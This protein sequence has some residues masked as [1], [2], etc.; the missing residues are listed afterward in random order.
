MARSPKF[1]LPV[2]FITLLGGAMILGPIFYYAANLVV[3]TPFHRAMDRALLVSAVAALGLFWSR[4][5][6]KELWRWTSDSWKQL[7]LGYITAA[8]IAQAIIGFVLAGVGFTSALLSTS[9]IMQRILVTL[10]AAIL[11]PPLEETVFRGF[12]QR[13]MIERIGW[14]AGWIGTAAIFMFAHFLK[15][16]SDLAYQPVHAWSGVTAI[17]SAFLP[18]IHGDFFCGRGLN[19]FLLGLIL[20]GIMLRNTTL[21][22][23]AGLHSGLIVAV[24][25]F[26]GF[27]HLT[28]PPRV[29]YLGGDILSSPIT[30][31]VF[32][33]LGLWLW[34]YYRHPSILPE[35]GPTAP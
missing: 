9:E 15:V 20:G 28:S 27:A 7:L 10:I 2:F 11:V 30:S 23:N 3:P 4:L 26:T 5:G 32:V 14:R 19:L 31:M 21:W 6:L 34:R 1:I 29:S 24:L 22:F 25:L 17:G 33:L 13:E 16:P 8:V 18:I 12:L 35:S